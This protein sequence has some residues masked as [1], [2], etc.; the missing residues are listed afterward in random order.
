MLAIVEDGEETTLRLHDGVHWVAATLSQ[1]MAHHVRSGVFEVGDV[2]E[3]VTTS[4]YHDDL[5]IVSFTFLL[6]TTAS[7]PLPPHPT[8]ATSTSTQHPADQD[9]E[10]K[11]S[12]GPEDGGYRQSATTEL[13]HYGSSRSTV[14]DCHLSFV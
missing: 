8:S 13:A 6:L 5:H 12:P 9:V 7:S 14:L 10:E 11:V 1:T 2:V 3:V 4:G